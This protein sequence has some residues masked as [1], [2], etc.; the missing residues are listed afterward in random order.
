MASVMWHCGV[1]EPIMF[2]I[3][4]TH[5]DVVKKNG[6]NAGE[7]FA[8]SMFEAGQKSGINEYLKGITSWED[9]FQLAQFLLIKMTRA[10]IGMN[11]AEVAIS[12][13]MNHENSRYK[14]RMAIQYS[15]EGETSLEEKAY[16]LAD[17]IL[18]EDSS[19]HDSREQLKKAILAGYNLHHEDF[20]D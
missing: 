20:D 10:G 12:V 18:Q 15:R 5:K 9:C 2:Y 8:K 1:R 16:E 3:M 14:S 7:T 19:N 4:N 11:A 6:C 13:E 17:K